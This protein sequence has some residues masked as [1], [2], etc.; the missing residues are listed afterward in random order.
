MPET[1]MDSPTASPSQ[2][3]VP[4]AQRDTCMPTAVAMAGSMANKH[5]PS[6]QAHHHH[7]DASQD[8]KGS[9]IGQRRPDQ[10]GRQQTVH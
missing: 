3:A 6:R 8:G 4:A 1:R 10:A 7:G 9:Y 2:M 5:A